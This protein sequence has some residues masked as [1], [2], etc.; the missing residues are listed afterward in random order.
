MENK[1]II[2]W[3]KKVTVHTVVLKFVVLKVKARYKNDLS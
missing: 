2:F 1:Q 3:R